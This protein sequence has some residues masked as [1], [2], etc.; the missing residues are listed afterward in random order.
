MFIRPPYHQAPANQTGI[1]TLF[2]TIVMLLVVTVFAIYS[3]RSTFIEQRTST[4]QLKRA[5]AFNAAQSGL[6]QFVAD[7]FDGNSGVGTLYLTGVAGNYTGVKTAYNNTPN[8]RGYLNSTAG[9]LYHD[10]TNTNSTTLNP[11]NNNANSFSGVT[12][13]QPTGSNQISSYT[14]YLTDLGGGKLRIFSRGCADAV[15]PTTQTATSTAYAEAV[16]S[17]D[18]NANG[19][20]SACALDINGSLTEYNGSSI[21][22]YTDQQTPQVITCGIRV[23]NGVISGDGSALDVKDC[24]GTGASGGSCGAYNTGTHSSSQASYFQSIFGQSMSTVQAA[25]TTLQISGT[26]GAGTG[27]AASGSDLCAAITSA[28]AASPKKTVI[29]IN[30]NLDIS[31]ATY[32]FLACA[33]EGYQ[34]LGYNEVPT[35]T[36]QFPIEGGG[37]ST[38][39]PLTFIVT[40]DASINGALKIDGTLYVGGSTTS[41]ASGSIVVNGSAAF[42]GN[43]STNA[44]LRVNADSAITSRTTYPPASTGA[45]KTG[46]SWKDF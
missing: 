19:G 26:T 29:W 45:A 40:G 43:V 12:L 9:A 23:S 2:V 17:I 6:D 18:I 37:S 36:G 13:T 10:F 1:A 15:C 20:N 46:Q 24:P 31:V 42:Y 25:S 39:T 28:N 32:P 4:N 11:A 8:N 34:A 33:N 30:G 35:G 41:T 38:S 21:H 14:I 7:I 3:N 22:G 16:I 44:S 5:V 27:G